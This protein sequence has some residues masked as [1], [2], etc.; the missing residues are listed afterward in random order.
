MAPR[1]QTDPL[2]KSLQLHAKIIADNKLFIVS[3][4][5][6]NQNFP[7]LFVS[8]FPSTTEIYDLKFKN[9]LQKITLIT[10]EQ[11]GPGNWSECSFTFFHMPPNSYPICTFSENTWVRNVITRSALAVCRQNQS[12]CVFNCAYMSHKKSQ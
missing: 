12:S 8:F 9:L 6:T 10:S 11:A 7:D 3:F 5:L 2:Y 4:K 1:I